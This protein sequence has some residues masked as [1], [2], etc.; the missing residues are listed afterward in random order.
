[1]QHKIN[2]KKILEH[3]EKFLSDDNFSYYSDQNEVFMRKH[4][5]PEMTETQA[6]DYLEKN[7]LFNDNKFDKS[8]VLM[9][10]DI[11]R[12]IR[13]EIYFRKQSA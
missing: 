7:F 12:A 8:E 2:F 10:A 13:M 1:M 3:F 9:A 6:I 5:S 11:L 4:L